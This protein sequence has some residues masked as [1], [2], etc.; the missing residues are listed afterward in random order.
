[1]PQC[2]VTL[3]TTVI[4]SWAGTSRAESLPAVDSVLQR[5][6]ARFSAVASNTNSPYYT[7]EKRSVVEELDG[8]GKA[9]NSEERLYQV[10]LIAGFPFDRLLQIKGKPLT[11]DQLKQEQHRQEQLQK[12]ISG[13]EVKKKVAHKEGWVTQQLLDRFTFEVQERVTMNNRSALVLG[14]HPRKDK[15]PA[16]TIQDKLLNQLAGT[17][18]VDEVDADVAKLSVKLLGPISLGW[19]G[20]V[21]SLN[22]CEFE[23]DRQLLPSDVWALSRQTL[24]LQGRMLVMRFAYRI[25]EEAS[26]FKLADPAVEAHPM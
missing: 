20:I 26:G 6:I 21:G 24:L 5:M 18:W 9:V 4:L 10:D 11:P 12:K 1:M 25:K 3:V 14:F 2:V 23:A 13:I 7:F 16:K 22:S 8:H 17:V 19:L 15:Q